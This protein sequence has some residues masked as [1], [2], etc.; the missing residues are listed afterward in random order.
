MRIPYDQPSPLG[1]TFIEL[2]EDVVAAILMTI[3]E[4]WKLALAFD[5][6]HSK[7]GEVAMTERLRDGMRVTLRA[8]DH[9]WGKVLI[10]LPGTESRSG[11]SVLLPDGRTDIP[12]VSLNVFLRTQEHDPHAILEC[13]RISGSDAHLCREYVVEGMDRFRLGKYGANHAAGFLVGYV[14]SG[15]DLEVVDGVNGFLSRASR[16]A[17]RLRNETVVDSVQSWHSIHPRT[18]PSSPIRL[19]HSLLGLD[20][21]AA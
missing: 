13:K 16:Q 3:R 6:V 8:K 17:E 10:I 18:P 11:P 1:T 20:S 21:V 15:T 19:H 12:I 7:A 4:G 5:D 14:L 2:T 9:P